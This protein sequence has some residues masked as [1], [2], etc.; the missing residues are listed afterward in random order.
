MSEN[1]DFERF[2]QSL[3]ERELTVLNNG[4]ASLELIESAWLDCPITPKALQAAVVSIRND[5]LEQVDDLLRVI[6]NYTE[7]EG[8]PILTK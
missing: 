3:Q 4:K 8:A 2:L 7:S 6:S 5:F 1:T